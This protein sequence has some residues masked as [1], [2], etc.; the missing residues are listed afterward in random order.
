ML[1]LFN[2]LVHTMLTECGPVYYQTVI[3]YAIYRAQSFV[4]PIAPILAQRVA[5][6]II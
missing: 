2:P 4:N 5:I 3:M 6:S 1:T